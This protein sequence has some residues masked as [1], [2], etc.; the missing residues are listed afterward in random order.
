[1]YCS[2]GNLGLCLS[3]NGRVSLTVPLISK[4]GTGE[5]SGVPGGVGAAHCGRLAVLYN[6]HSI[7]ISSS[8]EAGQARGERRRPAP[9]GM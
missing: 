4:R 2:G 3:R 6:R 7:I 8:R 9:R 5:D 1:M